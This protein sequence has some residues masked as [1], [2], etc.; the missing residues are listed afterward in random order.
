MTMQPAMNTVNNQVDM[1]QG[2]NSPPTWDNSNQQNDA[3]FGGNWDATLGEVSRDSQWTVVARKARGNGD[4]RPIKCA[5]NHCVGND[6]HS[7]ER[8]GN[9]VKCIN[10][11][12][13]NGGN[14][15]KTTVIVDSG[16]VDSVGP[17]TMAMDVKV[18]DTPASRAGLKYRAANGTAIDNQGE[19]VIQA[20]TKQDKKIGMT[21]QIANVTKSLGSVRAMLDAGNRVI[22]Q[23]GNS[24]IE[25]RSG[26]IKTP[27]EER[28]GAFVFDL[29]KPKSGDNQAGTI[30]TGRFQA[31]MEDDSGGNKGFV[32]QAGLAR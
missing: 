9:Q 1:N 22:F 2:D 3:D 28:N 18:R 5:G 8:A 19:K 23:K 6:L 21:F 17:P 30:H 31:L 27:I 24:Y 25:D 12:T 32:R 15:E 29:W 14:W 7:I 20:I 10:E 26:T 13:G 11:V 4:V 16:A